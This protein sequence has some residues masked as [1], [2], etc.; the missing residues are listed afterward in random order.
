[1]NQDNSFHVKISSDQFELTESFPLGTNVAFQGSGTIAKHISQ[2]AGDG[3]RIVSVIVP[4]LLEVKEMKDGV[5]IPK[6]ILKKNTPGRKSLSQRQRELVY[7]LHTERGGNEETFDAFYDQYM[8]V[9][10]ERLKEL[11]EKAKA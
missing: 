3:E 6:S 9:Q 10:E 1:M 11:I 7:I 5:V 4:D 2:V 8:K